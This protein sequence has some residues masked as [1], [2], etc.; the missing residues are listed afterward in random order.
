MFAYCLNNPVLYSDSS[1]S[2]AC[3]LSRDASCFDAHP[4]GGGGAIVGF[5]L[6]EAVLDATSTAQE[7]IDDQKE[8][9]RGKLTLS[10]SKA[11][12]RQ[13]RTEYEEHHL[14]ARKSPNAA[15]AA[16]IL[17]KVLPGGVEDPLNKVLVKT[18]V[19]RR[20]H[21]NL[22]YTF[23]NNLVIGAYLH[24]DGNIQQQHSNVIAALT[25]LRVFVESLNVLA[26]N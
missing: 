16:S 19:H 13:Y 20:L 9:I 14:V 7:W 18:S 24:A 22:Y 2:Y 11:K 3:V 8:A 21:T 5:Y 6:I 17:N 4:A 10:L 26:I 23:A 12:P 15:R 25:G 1:G